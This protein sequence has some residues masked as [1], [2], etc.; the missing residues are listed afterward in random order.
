MWP[1]AR[2][3]EPGLWSG[4]SQVRSG[5]SGAV[6]TY[7][8]KKQKNAP[9]CPWRTIPGPFCGPSPGTG[10]C[11]KEPWETCG[12]QI[13]VITGTARPSCTASLSPAGNR[14]SHVSPQTFPASQKPGRLYRWLCLCQHLGGG[15]TLLPG[16]SNRSVS[17]NSP[18]FFLFLPCDPGTCPLTSV[19]LCIFICRPW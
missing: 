12:S 4:V 13:S 14:G 11:D 2:S 8:G 9:S 7:G 16:E 18:C 19:S 6:L 10:G 15:R 1:G 3:H 5:E 17:P